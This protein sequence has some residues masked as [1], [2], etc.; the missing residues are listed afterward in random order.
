M[1]GDSRDKKMESGK[2]HP[3]SERICRGTPSLG[4]GKKK[5]A[6]IFIYIQLYTYIHIYRLAP[7]AP[8][9]KGL[10]RLRGAGRES[11][12]TSTV[13]FLPAG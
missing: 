11:K 2:V 8:T 6:Y 5:G 12:R 9:T 7:G 4:E 10:N 13:N 1:G 3:L